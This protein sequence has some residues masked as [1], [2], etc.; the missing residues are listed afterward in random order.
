MTTYSSVTCRE[1]QDTKREGARIDGLTAS[2]TLGCAFTDRFAL[3]YDLLFGNAGY[4]RAWPY[5]GALFCT[6]VEAADGPPGQAQTAPLNTQGY[7]VEQSYV[8]AT[9]STPS[10]NPNQPDVGNVTENLEPTCEF[11][12]LPHTDFIWDGAG[13]I[14]LK[15]EEAPAK[16]NRGVN[17]V[18]TL[19]KIEPPLPIELITLQ[20]CV[21]NGSIVSTSLGLTFPAETL[22]YRGVSLSR[23]MQPGADPDAADLAW[24][25]TLKFGVKYSEWNKFW[26]GP[27]EGWQG[28]KIKAT[29]AAYKNYPPEDFSVFF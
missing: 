7:E 27:L 20:G 8:V 23:T 6:G 24:N 9:Y 3:M 11:Q 16:Q 28:F 29:G 22:M 25:M 18:R 13:Q 19:S 21:N 10:M 14:V 1:I 17:Y 2:V 15:P 12:T 5:G 26:R 4:G